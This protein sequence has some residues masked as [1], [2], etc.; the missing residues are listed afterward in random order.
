M[1]GTTSNMKRLTLI[2][3]MIFLPL[4]STLAQDRGTDWRGSPIYLDITI[5]FTRDNPPD[6]NCV[7]SAL[8]LARWELV[9]QNVSRD[10]ITM[11]WVNYVMRSP[12]L[13]STQQGLLVCERH[14]DI[15]A[16]V[17]GVLLP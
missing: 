1:A 4:Y 17:S 3:L 12:D 11:R 15:R 9:S 8:G 6:M 7:T 10:T 2:L 5:I 13:I 14:I 16:N